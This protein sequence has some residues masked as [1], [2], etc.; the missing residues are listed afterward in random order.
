MEKLW[1][2]IL[3][4]EGG[5]FAVIIGFIWLN[6]YLDLPHVLFKAPLTP[7][8]FTEALFET[9]LIVVLGGSATIYTMV[10]AGRLQKSDREK[11]RLLEVIA[12]DLRSPFTTLLGNTELLQN[13]PEDLSE[14]DRATLISDVHQSAAN[15]FQTLENLL[16]WARLRRQHAAPEPELIEARELIDEIVNDLADQW[17][18]KEVTITNNLEN[19]TRIFADPTELRSILRNLISNAIKF[20]RPQG[21]VELTGRKRGGKTRIE[22]IDHGVG[23]TRKE[24]KLLM[25]KHFAFSKRGTRGEKGSGIG[26]ML[27]RELT[28]RNGGTLKL[29]SA[30][31]KGSVFTLQLPRTVRRPPKVEKKKKRNTSAKSAANPPGEA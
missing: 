19:D 3:W 13:P 1:R 15:T 2:K 10:L 16:N 20:S 4:I 28:R 24:Q 23:L 26:L 7:F 5:A 29:R 11:N 30:P 8:N 17:R 22:V 31:D 14:E 25:N 6:E 9:A 21:K 12:H 18:D 27:V